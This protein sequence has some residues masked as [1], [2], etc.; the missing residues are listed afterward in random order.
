MNANAILRIIPLGGL[1][2]IGMNCMALEVD[3]EILVID[4]GVTFPR[5]D[6]GI[7]TYRPDLSWL[8]ERQSS[9]RGLVLTHGHEDHIGAVPAFLERFDVPVWGPPYALELVK[10]RLEE[11]GF[12]AGSYDLRPSLPRRRFE[13]GRFEV[14][15][16]RVTHSIVDATA[17]VVRTPAGTVVHTGDFKMDG[18]PD[19]EELTDEERFREVG[20]EGVRLLLSD[21]T[22]IDSPG[23]S[24]NEQAAVARLREL[25]DS[26]PAR[27]V[28][29]LFASN[30]LRLR[31]LGE[32]AASSGRKLILLGRSV[33]THSRIGRDL[34][35]LPWSSDLVLPPEQIPHTPR[36]RQLILA[37]GTQG[38]RLAALWKLSSR[39]H[40]TVQLAEGDRVIFSSRVIPGNEPTVTQMANGFLRQGIQ[41][42]TATNYPGIHI[43][44]H[45]YRDEQARMIDLVRPR[46]FLP[47]HGTLLHLHRHAELA[48]SRGVP[49][50]TVLENG[51]VGELTHHTPFSRTEDHAHT[52]R[53]ATWMG[54][55]IPERV[56]QDRELL[57]RVGI[58]FITVLADTRGRPVGPVSVT[59]RGVFDE[60][61]DGDLLREAARETLRTLREHAYP[62]ERPTDEEIA[63]LARLT[64]RR[65]LESSTGRRPV[66]LAQVIR[67]R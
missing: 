21:S 5:S 25:I 41:V 19:P 13:A 14:E 28:V 24:G 1:G 65:Y 15:P 46:G 42:C 40:P 31:T 66:V 6:I 11:Y 36:A 58:A 57:A 8:E 38:E 48:R 27:V 23:T 43:S 32:I 9:L 18:A 12:H 2:E 29:G 60:R 54:E 3:G 30:V 16:I 51:Q 39:T 45:A 62:H 33:V 7:D 26:A 22:N 55:D 52:G 17:L 44:G 10:L 37:T 20:D 63:D 53:I 34:G 67:V 47:I 4:C 61:R 35:K 64:T 59:S 56:L 50:V 49:E